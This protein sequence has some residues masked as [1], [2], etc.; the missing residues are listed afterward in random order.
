MSLGSLLA[1]IFVLVILGVLGYAI[2]VLVPMEPTT[3]R[4]TMGVIA[5]AAVL[6]VV[7]W[8]FSLLG[9]HPSAG[10]RLW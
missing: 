2:S 5:V 1:L 6:V 4:V 7:F 3:K 9:Y 8:C 10:T